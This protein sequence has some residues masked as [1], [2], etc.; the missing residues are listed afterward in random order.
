VLL[1]LKIRVSERPLVS[2]MAMHILLTKPKVDSFATKAMV[3]AR[4]RISKP[5]WFLSSPLITLQGKTPPPPQLL[6]SL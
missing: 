5:N 2:W 1:D 6:A 4:I 3:S